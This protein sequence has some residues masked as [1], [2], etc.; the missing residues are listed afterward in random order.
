ML[1]A[2]VIVMTT[3]S[4]VVLLASALGLACACDSDEEGGNAERSSAGAGGNGATGGNGGASAN[5]GSAGS[6]GATGG[7][8]GS[9]A[10]GGSG[11]AGA[12]DGSAGTV[13]VSGTG[14][15]GGPQACPEREPRSPDPPYTPEKC[16][17]ENTRQCTY[18]TTLPNRPGVTCR[19]T[20]VCQ[21]VSDQMGGLDCAWTAMQV[22][23]PDAGL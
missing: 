23:C 14:G 5:G 16:Y 9:G 13:G 4:A 21:C 18:N 19:I 10:I 7:T 3:R 6:A 8:A 11:A 12:R 17:R 22:M 2:S 1:V 20:F 15:S